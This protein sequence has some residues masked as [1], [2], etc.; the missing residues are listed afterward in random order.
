MITQQVR[1]LEPEISECLHQLK[2]TLEMRSGIFVL[3]S[4]VVS[5]IVGGACA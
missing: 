3:L 1:D 4:G 2:V 5:G